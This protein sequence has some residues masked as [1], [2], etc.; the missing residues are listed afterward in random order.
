MNEPILSRQ[1]IAVDADA[2]ALRAV[3]HG[4]E[5]PNPHLVGSD[6]HAAWHAAYCRYLLKHSAPETVEGGA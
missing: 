5:Q 6:A 1:Q 4:V 3:N 2:A